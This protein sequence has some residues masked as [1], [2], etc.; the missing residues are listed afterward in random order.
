MLMNIAIL[1]FAAVFCT[2]LA[3]YYIVHNR[4]NWQSRATKK[5]L[6]DLS[7]NTPRESDQISIL[8]QEE[9]H[10]TIPLVDRLLNLFAIGDYLK[11]LIIQAGSRTNPGTVFLA[12]GSIGILALLILHFLTHNVLLSALI[13]PA[14]AALPYFYLV[15]K[16]SKRIRNFEEQLPEALDMI[17]NALRSGFT[18]ELAIKLVAQELPDPLG[19]EFAVVFEEQNLGVPLADALAGMRYRVPT[20]ELDILI[21]TLVL[22]RRT[23]GNL[24][25]V[26]EKASST[27][28]ARFRL[29]REVR[30]KTAHGRFSGFV[31]IM[32]PLGLIVILMAMAPDYLLMMLNDKMGQYLLATAVIMQIIGIFI[33]R[34]ITNIKL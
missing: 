18:F 21:I 28:R 15:Y 30:T 20:D 26:L 6:D 34:K 23:G 11:K 25:E 10:S 31:L 5:R 4:L 17:V 29:K 24:A 9:K 33:I 2:T 19:Y 8:R 7:E 12:I 14:P 1:V 16:R 13:A 32:L 22:H 27:I 3:V